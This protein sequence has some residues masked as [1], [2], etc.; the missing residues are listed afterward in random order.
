MEGYT[1]GL[2]KQK[3]EGYGTSMET[4]DRDK[5]FDRKKKAAE[6][7]FTTR[8]KES[9][10]TLAEFKNTP[11]GK[12]LAQDVQSVESQRQG[13]GMYNTAES[14]SKERKPVKGYVYIR[15]SRR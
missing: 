3:S 12:K 1:E 7:V 6:L 13:F 9:G 11:E 2:I 15:R 10:L 8:L 5:D 14:P 4:T